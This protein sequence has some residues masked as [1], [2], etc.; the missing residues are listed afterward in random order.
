[1]KSRLK[2]K[3]KEVIFQEEDNQI[4]VENIIKKSAEIT[5][6]VS[7]NFLVWVFDRKY[8]RYLDTENKDY[9]IQEHKNFSYKTTQELFEEF[10]NNY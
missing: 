1:M 4:D 3:I 9:W 10:I 5:N 8:V 6:D 2:N 7:I